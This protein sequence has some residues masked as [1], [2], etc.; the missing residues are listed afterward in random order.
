ML[1]FLVG[2]MHLLSAWISVL[3]HCLSHGMQEGQWSELKV[4]TADPVFNEDP[5]PILVRVPAHSQVVFSVFDANQKQGTRFLGLC[6]IAV[7][8]LIK[9]PSPFMTTLPLQPSPTQVTPMPVSGTL[10]VVV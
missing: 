8:K 10:T 1:D 5:F 9:F 4:N 2:F 3:K 6:I 7:E